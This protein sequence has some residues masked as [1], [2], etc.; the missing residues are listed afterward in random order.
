ME[1][2]KVDGPVTRL[3]KFF[4]RPGDGYVDR[5]G[6]SVPMGPLDNRTEAQR[7]EARESAAMNLTNIDS[8]ERKRRIGLGTIM[9]IVLVGVA[10]WQIKSG[11]S[12]W[13]RAR[14]FP[15]FFLGSAELASGL[16]GL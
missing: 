12:P 14:I 8:E 9:L 16:S 11:A 4:F 7:Q 5:Y 3:W 13:D 15:I 1:S 6:F 2:E 10:A